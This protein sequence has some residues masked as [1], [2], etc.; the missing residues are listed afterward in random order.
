MSSY[1]TFARA[2]KLREV[3][4]LKRLT[5]GLSY[6]VAYCATIQTLEPFAWYLIIHDRLRPNVIISYQQYDCA[7]HSK[8]TFERELSGVKRR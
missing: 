6:N 4:V 3:I 1:V 8:C 7:A 5:S 2:E